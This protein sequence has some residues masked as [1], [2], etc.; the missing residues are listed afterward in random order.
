MQLPSSSSLRCLFSHW[1]VGESPVESF[2]FKYHLPQ[3]LT[4]F[5]LIAMLFE[6]KTKSLQSL[7]L[8]VPLP[9][10]V[11]DNFDPLM[12]LPMSLEFYCPGCDFILPLGSCARH[13]L[14]YGFCCLPVA[15][16]E[17][18]PSLFLPLFRSDNRDDRRRRRR[19]VVPIQLS[20]R[21]GAPSSENPPR[22]GIRERQ[23]EWSAGYLI[24]WSIPERE[25]DKFRPT[26]LTWALCGLRS[27]QICMRFLLLAVAKTAEGN[28]LWLN[29]YRRRCC[30]VFEQKLPAW[31]MS[32][33][34]A[35]RQFLGEIPS[36]HTE[37]N[38]QREVCLSNV[39]ASLGRRR[40]WGGNRREGGK[41]VKSLSSWIIDASNLAALAAAFLKLRVEARYKAGTKALENST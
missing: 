22:C 14:A 34:N 18:P 35:C 7:T 23:I 4:S 20:Q 25:F 13:W 28:G 17:L 1:L 39:N 16:A 40:R 29:R 3:D 36:S 2:L 19:D 41:G 21:N 27:D 24:A 5:P 11:C 12:A 33:C 9:S 8:P 30:C 26:D 32:S 31:F 6:G 10:W 15:L 37:K 38:W